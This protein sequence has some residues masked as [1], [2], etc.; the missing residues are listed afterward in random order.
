[1]ELGSLTGSIKQ[2]KSVND[3]LI[4][5]TKFLA[6]FTPEAEEAVLATGRQFGMEA[7]AEALIQTMKDNEKNTKKH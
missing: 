6:W 3:K 4:F 5:H 1:M 2:Y 7:E